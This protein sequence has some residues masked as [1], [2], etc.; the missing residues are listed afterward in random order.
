M[1]R[2]KQPA[3]EP[4]ELEVHGVKIRFNELAWSVPKFAEVVDHGA[5]TIR[6]EIDAGNLN[7]RWSRPE[8][9]VITLPDALEW[10]LTLPL[11][12]PTKH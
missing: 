4:I 2:K 7:A 12:K 1:T 8:K 10:L 6:E 11:D 9:R 5:T 3:P